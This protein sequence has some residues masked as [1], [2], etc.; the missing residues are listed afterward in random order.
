MSLNESLDRVLTRYKELESLMSEGGAGGEERAA[1][2]ACDDWE[3]LWSAAV[4]EFDPDVVVVQVGPWEVFDR[5]EGSEWVPFGSPR[6]DELL[7]AELTDLV[8]VVGADGRPVEVLD[9]AGLVCPGD[10]G[11]CPERIDGVRV[12]GDGIHY[13]DEGGRWAARWLAPQ[14]RALALEAADRS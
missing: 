14:L 4:D 3:G 9:L 10:D 8:E 6:H 5:R 7:T 1:S 11:S 13:T 2:D 12:R